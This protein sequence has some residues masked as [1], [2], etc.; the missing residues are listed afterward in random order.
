MLCFS[1]VFWVLML[2]SALY[3]GGGFEANND[4]DKCIQ[5]NAFDS[6]F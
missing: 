2:L 6:F 3:L 1:P 5:N 4:I